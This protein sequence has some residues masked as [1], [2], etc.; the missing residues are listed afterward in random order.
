[1]KK[2]KM[3]WLSF[4]ICL[5]ITGCGKSSS[6]ADFIAVK[7]IEADKNTEA[8]S[9]PE[10]D[11]GDDEIYVLDSPEEEVEGLEY[12]VLEENQ[13]RED[14]VI[15]ERIKKD[16]KEST[17]FYYEGEKPNLVI[18]E[19]VE[20]TENS[21]AYYV[22]GIS[23]SAFS[24]NDKLKSIVLP[25]SVESIGKEAFVYCTSLTT[26]TLPKQM[27]DIAEGAF[28]GCEKLTSIVIPEGITTIYTDTFSN[29]S[30]LK[31]IQFP[32]TL[33]TIEAEAF[34]YCEALETLEL[35]EGLET[36]GE[37]AFY[38]CSSLKT[39][40]CPATLKDVSADIFQFCDQLETV[41]VPAD[42]VSEYEELF[43]GAPFA[44]AAK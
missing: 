42:R 20:D 24:E 44:I 18:P 10:D 5:V 34:W 33:K 9:N 11:L 32:S 22:I 2:K 19:E 40:T 13:Y 35:P 4:L 27:K 36:I 23:D 16:E 26:V 29:C 21:M 39:V 30:A 14:E 43:E 8:T 12:F 7:D 28:F 3:I 41:Y 1:M 17:V 6:S 15:Y 38:N 31:E 37:R 25:D